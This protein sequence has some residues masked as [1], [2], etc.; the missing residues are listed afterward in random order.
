MIMPESTFFRR[1]GLRLSNWFSHVN[2]R[3]TRARHR[4][5]QGLA[6]ALA[7]SLAGAIS[8]RTDDARWQMSLGLNSDNARYEPS[9]QKRPD[10][11]FAVGVNQ[12]VELSHPEWL[13]ASLRAEALADGRLT[14][15]G[16]SFFY[17]DRRT[18]GLFENKQ[19]ATAALD[20]L[21]DVY[22]L[23]QT[24]TGDPAAA[25]HALLLAC[26]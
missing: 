26:H 17:R 5:P 23:A 18:L 22:K 3:F 11:L 4:K 10:G 16:G 8:K 25:N 24:A 12:C 2:D 15:F 13:P 20:G 1:Q 7:D 6:G 21:T 14:E 9:I 19:K